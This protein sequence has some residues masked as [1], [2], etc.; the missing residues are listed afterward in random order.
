MALPA[1]LGPIAGAATSWGLNNIFGGG[2][3]QQSDPYNQFA[4]S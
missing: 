4:L 1:I 3:S 2:S